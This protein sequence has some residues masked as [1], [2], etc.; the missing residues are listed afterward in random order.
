MASWA[1]RSSHNAIHRFILALQNRL[2]R[3]AQPALQNRRIHTA[4]IEMHLQIPPLIEIGQT[5]LLAVH[6]G[7]H[8]GAHHEHGLSQAVIG[9]A[10]EV[11]LD[12]PSELAE[13]ECEHAVSI[14]LAVEVAVKRRQRVVELAEQL[15]EPA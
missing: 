10:A 1:T 13:R 8:T 4:E 12:A 6:T 7:L 11:F 9:S 14:A 2:A 5:R 3:H 15:I